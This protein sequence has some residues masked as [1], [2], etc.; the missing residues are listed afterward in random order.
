[1]GCDGLWRLVLVCDGFS[2]VVMACDGLRWVV[3][4]YDGFSWLVIVCAICACV[5]MCNILTRNQWT[6]AWDLSGPGPSHDLGRLSCFDLQVSRQEIQ[7][8]T[9]P[10]PVPR[11]DFGTFNRDWSEIIYSKSLNV[12]ILYIYTFFD[13]ISA[14]YLACFLKESHVVK[15]ESIFWKSWVKKLLRRANKRIVKT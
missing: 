10:R 4:A 6:W 13:G 1:M 14:I 15:L 8:K 12:R 3:V 2:S 11:D 5:H 9:L 7:K